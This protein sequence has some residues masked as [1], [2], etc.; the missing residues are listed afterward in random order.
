MFKNKGQPARTTNKQIKLSAYEAAKQ[1]ERQEP[2][3]NKLAAWLENRR[4][5]NGFGE[6]FEYTLRPRGAK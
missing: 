1:L 6:D 3:V 4:N 2:R 5:Q